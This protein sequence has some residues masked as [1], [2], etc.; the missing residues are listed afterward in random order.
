MSPKNK[1]SD[2]TNEQTLWV[3]MLKSL[4]KP[5]FRPDSLNKQILKDQMAGRWVVFLFLFAMKDSFICVQ[6]KEGKK[7]KTKQMVPPNYLRVW[8]K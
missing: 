2:S 3:E 6:K 5:Q 8:C 1:M 7:K 4:K